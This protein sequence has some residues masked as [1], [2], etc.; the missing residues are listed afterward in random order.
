M[1]LTMTAM[2]YRMDALD[3][4]NTMGIKMQNQDAEFRCLMMRSYP[5]SGTKYFDM[6]NHV[7]STSPALIR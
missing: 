1:T 6:F 4:E 2:T 7:I 3:F 5:G